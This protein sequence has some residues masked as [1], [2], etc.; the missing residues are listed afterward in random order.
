[1]L[2]N[3]VEY[4]YSHLQFAM[5][6]NS[7][8]KGVQSISYKVKKESEN[9]MGTG[10]DPVG[11]GYGPNEYEGEIKLMRKTIQAIRR[12][13]GNKSL[14]EVPPF[15]IVHSFANGVDPIKTVT[16]RYVRF[17]EDGLEGAT[18]DKEL[19]LT[20]PIGLSGIVHS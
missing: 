18:G 5:L 3:G 17:M 15:D 13:S 14:T 20:I 2:E 12:A 16:L 8:V 1:M 10:D 11:I 7:D 9:L 4:S 19:P 6:G